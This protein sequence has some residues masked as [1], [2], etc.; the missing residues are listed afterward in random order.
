[1]F[2]YMSLIALNEEPFKMIVVTLGVITQ[3]AIALVF[4][5][6]LGPITAVVFSEATKKDK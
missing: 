6:A 4:A 2:D 3:V 1:M 5:L